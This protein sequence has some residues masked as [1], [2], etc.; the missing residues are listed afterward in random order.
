MK[1]R[2]R[3]YYSDVQ[4]ALMWG[5]WQKG[6][7]LNAIARLFDRGHSSIQGILAETGGIRPRPV[8]SEPAPSS[9]DS[10]SSAFSSHGHSQELEWPIF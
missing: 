6:E 7:P 4:K 5:R 3:I 10:V 9:R 8:N 1:Q 2:P